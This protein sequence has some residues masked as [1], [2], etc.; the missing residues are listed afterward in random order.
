MVFLASLLVVLGGALALDSSFNQ[1]ISF[2]STFQNVPRVANWASLPFQSVEAR[3]AVHLS[4]TCDSFVTLSGS[5]LFVSTR[6]ENVDKLALKSPF[7]TWSALAEVPSALQLIKSANA[8]FN[9]FAVTSGNIVGLNFAHCGAVAG[10]ANILPVEMA[11]GQVL[12]VASSATHLWV[13][14]SNL[15]LTQIK[16]SDG[17]SRQ[18]SLQDVNIKSLHFVPEWNKLYVGSELALYT[19][20]FETSAESNYLLHHEWITGVIDSVPLQFSFDSANNA[21]WLAES[22][23]VHKQDVQGRWWRYG[24]HQGA[25]FGNITSVNVVDG[26]VYVGS[27]LGLAR[28][29]SNSNPAQVD[30]LGNPNEQCNLL[31][32]GENS[33]ETVDCSVTA[34]PWTW[35][36]YAGNRYLPDNAVATLAS[37]PAP[38]EGPSKSTVVLVATA[39]G[40]TFLE[41]A[42]WTLAEKSEAMLQFQYPRHERGKQTSSCGLSVYGDLTTYYKTVSDNDG[43]WTAMHGIGEAYSYAA[44]GSKVSRALAWTAFEA[45]EML[46]NVTGVFPTFPARSYC[47]IAD[48]DAGCGTGDGAARWHNSTVVEGVM[49]KDDTSSDE[50][51]GHYAALPVMYDL[52]AETEEEK[53]RVYTIIDGL[54]EGLIKNDLYLVDPS[55]G[56]HTTWGFWNPKDVNDNPAHYSERGLNSLEILSYLATA[57]SVTRRSLYKDT[58]FKLVKQHGYVI[59]TMN[60]K[61]DNPEDDNHSD[62]EL[63]TL[64]FHAMFY[65]WQRISAEKEPQ[66]KA[67]M[68]EMAS[69]VLPAFERTW[70]LIGAEYSPLWTGIYA[71]VAAQQVSPASVA[72]SVWTLRHW[73]ID[74]INWPV[75]NANRWDVALEPFYSRDSTKQIMRQIRPPSERVSS[76]WNNDPFS[77]TEGSGYSE[78]EPAVWRLPY[79]IMLYYKLI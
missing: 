16:I 77:V 6:Q 62:N 41:T 11:W 66:F 43:L 53:A 30:T 34:D 20:K 70:L 29:K 60:V 26:Y 33:L 71:G 2:R 47:Y 23:A 73:A 64:A 68:W 21:L 48:G 79:Y 25:P 38:T 31:I 13:A 14:S 24:Y 55:T 37:A 40:L 65:S 15:G 17:S 1:D 3:A 51:N 50:M 4:P 45:L 49:W 75:D 36:F 46:Q 8:K 57:Y 32:G 18:I 74:L 44:T 42:P 67:E 56:Q 76:H 58:F 19:L 52:V 5:E 69:L 72:H 28:L 22:G 54:T 39:T 59:N 7:S 78:Y 63:I 10:S 27:A 9:L 35:S 61:I 12:A